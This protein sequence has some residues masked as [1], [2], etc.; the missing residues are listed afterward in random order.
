[1]RGDSAE[2]GAA[3]FAFKQEFREYSCR[4]NSQNPETRQRNWISRQVQH[5][6]QELVSQFVP[7]A[8]EWAHQTSISTRILAELLCREIDISIEARRG[9][10]IERMREWNF[11]LDPFKAESFQRERFEKG[12]TCRERMDRRTDI[13]QKSWQC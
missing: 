5:R 9:T 11:R 12:R 4:A 13:V 2:K 6:L 3:R 8:C 7:I 10:V 1:M